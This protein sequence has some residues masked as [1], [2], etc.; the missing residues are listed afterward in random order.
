MRTLKTFTAIA[1]LLLPLTVWAK[2]D[3]SGSYVVRGDQVTIQIAVGN[4]PPMAFIVM[5][6]IPKGVEV[7]SASPRPSG[8]KKGGASLK[9]L[10]KHAR[11]GTM[12][13]K[14]QLSKPVKRSQLKGKIRYQHP[15]GGETITKK[16]K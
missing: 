8:Y 5:Q 6:K 13:V 7:V 11:P 9:W 16:I 3:V 15:A 2:T 4:P 14:L 10:F 12:S 1:V